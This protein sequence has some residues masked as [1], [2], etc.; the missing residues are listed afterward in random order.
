MKSAYEL[1]MERLQGDE[2]VVKL[3]DE[4]RAEIA[5]IDKKFR[6]K[7][8]E[9]EVF[10]QGLLE[11]ARQGGDLDEIRQLQD[12]LTREVARLQREIE[13]AKDKVRQATAGK[14]ES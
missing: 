3:S 14:A 12:Q 6:A 13:E 7:I 5:E 4:Q 1:A 10:L 8:A 11:K 9:R 2:P